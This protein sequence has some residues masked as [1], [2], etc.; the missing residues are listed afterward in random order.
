M[1]YFLFIVWTK[2]LCIIKRVS[3]VDMHTEQLIHSTQGRRKSKPV[4]SLQTCG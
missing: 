4:F 2:D 3:W 1:M